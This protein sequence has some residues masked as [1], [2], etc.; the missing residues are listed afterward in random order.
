MVKLACNKVLTIIDY[1]P[2]DEFLAGDE[3]SS[4]LAASIT[5]ASG[6]PR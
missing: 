4:G 3:S 5:S 1:A 6:L 2:A